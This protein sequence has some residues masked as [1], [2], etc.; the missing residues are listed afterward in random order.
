MKYFIK[1]LAKNFFQPDEV[2]KLKKHVIYLPLRTRIN[3]Q[4][5][6]IQVL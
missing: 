2:T 5:K 6:F 1:N 3:I 4:S